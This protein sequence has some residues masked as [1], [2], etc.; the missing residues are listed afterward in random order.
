MGYEYGRKSFDG[1]DF[2][3]VIKH[4]NNCF[5]VFVDLDVFNSGY[6][7]VPSKEDPQ[8]AYNIEHVRKYCI[9]NPDKV[10]DKHP[11]EDSFYKKMNFENEKFEKEKQLEKVNKQLFNA[12]ID[13]VFAEAVTLDENGETTGE[14]EPIN[15]TELLNRRK[16]LIVRISEIEN[17][18]KNIINKGY[19]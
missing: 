8:G 17:E 19:F 15:V 6:G 13:V 2:G 10:F 18:I 11:L 5:T 4:N 12:L 1:M 14:K 9:K 7:V 16:E 3:Y